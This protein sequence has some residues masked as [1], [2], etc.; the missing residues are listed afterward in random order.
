ME[1]NN[2]ET[3]NKAFAPFIKKWYFWLIFIVFIIDDILEGFYNPEYLDIVF[4]TIMLHF[5]SLY[6]LFYFF[7][8]LFNKLIKRESINK[9]K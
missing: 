4:T 8:F 2:I 1:N 9:T 5:F 6:I 7:S 3:N